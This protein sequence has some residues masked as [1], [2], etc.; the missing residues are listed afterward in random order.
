M[1]DAIRAR[2]SYANITATIALFMALG[3]VSYAALKLP[4]G[5]VDTRQLHNGAVT[6]P[7]LAAGVLASLAGADGEPGSDGAPGQDGAAGPRGERGEPGPAGPIGPTG[8]AGPTEGAS[9]DPLPG[10]EHIDMTLDATAFT[11]TRAGR[12]W[13][14]KPIS[15]L[16]I[17]CSSGGFWDAFL[18]VDGVRVPGEI[19]RF[20][21]N[22]DTYPQITVSG[23]TGGL[24]A[25]EHT[26]GVGV[27]CPI[28]DGAH[29]NTYT[30][31]N[32]VSA[33]VL[34]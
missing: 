9:T 12:L 5:S 34:G 14:S 31:G 32:G 20:G 26:A 2:L 3:G 16:V 30:A 19:V 22:G 1:H 15:Q 6:K 17:S 24:A 7:K 4:A 11:T 8:P 29:P 25:G 28:G 18:V 33:I 23:V 27:D 13:V 10:T 21:H